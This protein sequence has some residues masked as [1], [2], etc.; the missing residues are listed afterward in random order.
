MKRVEKLECIDEVKEAIREA[1]EIF[2]EVEINS[3]LMPE[4]QHEILDI[5]DFALDLGVP[6]EVLELVWT[7]YNED[8]YNE[9]RMSTKDL[10][11][12]LVKRGGK[13]RIE[14]PGVGVNLKIIDFGKTHVK[15]MDNSLGSHYVGTCKTCELKNACVEGFWAIRVDP[16]GYAQPCLLRNDLRTDL[17][18]Y[19]GNQKQLEEFLPLWIAA[20]TKGQPLPQ[21]INT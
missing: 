19:L 20:F 17:K 2:P 13:E 8:E 12:I 18:A 21:T 3:L 5:V 9:K 4:N 11:D 1:K 14:T 16:E 6:I 15:L 7:G 10:A